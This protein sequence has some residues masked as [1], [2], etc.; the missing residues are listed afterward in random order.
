MLS[1]HI[2]I[3]FE[4]NIIYLFPSLLYENLSMRLFQGFDIRK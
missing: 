3:I 4:I 1:V 2:G